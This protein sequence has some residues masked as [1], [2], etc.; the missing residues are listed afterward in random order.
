MDTVYIREINYVAAR[1]GSSRP[2][3]YTTHLL[4]R[5][6]NKERE[7]A[8]DSCLYT[9]PEDCRQGKT[10]YRKV[11]KVLAFFDYLYYSCFQKERN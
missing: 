7:K 5:K 2:C 3:Y 9:S 8:T 11:A 1:K 6:V 10:G 4:F